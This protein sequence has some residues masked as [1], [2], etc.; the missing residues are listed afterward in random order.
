MDLLTDSLK[1]PGFFQLKAEPQTFMRRLKVGAHCKHLCSHVDDFG[2][3]V[4]DPNKLIKE[5]TE[6]PFCFKLKGT[7]PSN[8]HPGCG[9]GRDTD[10]QIPSNALRRH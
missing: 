1:Q 8:F 5:L 2:F 9:F 4:D 6:G 7:G 10:L 3:A